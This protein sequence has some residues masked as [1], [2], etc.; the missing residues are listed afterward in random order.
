MLKKVIRA[1]VMLSLALPLAALA[2]EAATEVEPI[3]LPAVD[4]LVVEGDINIAGSSTVFPL[5]EAVAELFRDEGYMGNITIASVGS[6]AGLERFCVAGEIDIANAS[7]VIT[8]EEIEACRAI[9]REPIEFR[10]G[11]D[12][13]TVVVSARNDF[14]DELTLEQLYQIFSGQAG[15]WAGVNPEWPAEPIQLF[16][17]GSDSG[18]FDYFVEAVFEGVGGLDGDDAAAALLNAPNIQLSEDD[19]VLVAGVQ[20]SPYAIGY[21]GYAYYQ[22]NADNLKALI[23]DGVEPTEETAQD[24]SY[25]LSRPLFMY[26]DAGIINEKPQVG[27]FIN[28]YLSHVNEV[29]IDVGYFPTSVEALNVAKAR[30][31]LAQ[32]LTDQIPADLLEAL[33]A[34]GEAEAA[35]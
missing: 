30:L 35:G 12:A 22:E 16:S 21:F 18:T 9:G 20:A 3:I 8:E 33:Q 17:P 26:S 34:E 14:V 4:P 1:G 11:T 25:P 24:N 6:G 31:L 7:R 27:D 32:G 15:T 2:Q 19:N 29:I 10:V 13:L 28:F 5:S 23:I